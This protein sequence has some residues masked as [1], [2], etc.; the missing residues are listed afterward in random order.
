MSNKP[1][2]IT[3][4]YKGRSFG[5]A[6]LTAAQL[7]IGTIHII[8]GF[9]LLASEE[10]IIKTTAA[11]DFYT[12]AFGTLVLVFTL[13][14]WQGKK[15]GWVGTIV[16]SVFV[17]VVDALTVLNLPSIPGIPKFAAPTEIGYSIIVVVY[18]L[19]SRVRKKYLG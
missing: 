14:I 7:L 9:L 1:K 5:I 12:V 11:Y 16:V 17:S 3:I 19:Q 2:P 6:V 8:F 10:S 15:L 4:T 13:F 18:L